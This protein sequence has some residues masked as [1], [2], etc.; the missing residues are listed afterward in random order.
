MKALVTAGTRGMGRAIAQRLMQS[1][2]ECIVTGTT[3]VSCKNVPDGATGLAADLTRPADVA[4]L[5]ETIAGLEIDI[6]VNNAGKNILGPTDEFADADFDALMTINLKAP[7][8]LCRAVIPY[9]KQRGWGRIVN[10]TSLWSVRAQRHDAAYCASK[11][12]LDGMTASLAPELAPHGILVNAVAPGYILTDA[13]AKGFA[14]ERIAKDAETI[15]LGRYGRPE[16]I[17]EIVAWLASSANSYMTGQNLLVD[18]GLSRTA[19][20]QI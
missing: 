2:C 9:M 19:F 7:F 16:E 5:A 12:G 6:L 4:R 17:A 20:P 11:F 14:E 13:V 8:S 15:P 10:I 3:E 18:G 1:G